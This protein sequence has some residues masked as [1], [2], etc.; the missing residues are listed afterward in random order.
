MQRKSVILFLFL[1]LIGPGFLQAQ[2][3]TPSTKK[4]V[5]LEDVWAYFTFFPQFGEGFSWMKDDQYYIVQDDEGLVQYSIQTRQPVKTIFDVASLKD[6][7]GQQLSLLS[8]EFNEDETKLLIITESR[9][10]YRRSALQ[11][12]YVWDI[13]TQKL[14]QL[15]A[16]KPVMYP[17]FSPDGSKIAYV[18]DNDLYFTELSTGKETRM[19]DDGKR[20]AIIN[21]ATDWVYEEEFAFTR[22]FEWSPDNNRIAFLQFNETDVPEYSMQTFKGALYPGNYEFKYPKAGEK[23]AIVNLFFYDLKIGK[24]VQGNLGSETDQYI[25][26]IRFTQDASKLAVFRLNRLQNSLDLLMVDAGT[27]TSTVLMNESSN[28]YVQELTDSKIHF[29][30]NGKGFLYLSESS[31]FNHIYLYGMD[32]KLQKAL[33]SGNWEVTDICGVDEKNGWIYFLSTEVS[34]LERH[35]NRV[36]LNGGTPQQL[37]KQAGMHEIEMSTACTYYIDTWSS[38]NTPPVMALYKASGEEVLVLEDNAELKKKLEGYSIQYPEFTKITTEEGVDLNGWMIKPSNFDKKKK[39]PVLLH[40]YGGPGAQEVLNQ[41]DYFDLFWYQMLADQGYIIACFDNR[42]TGGRGRDFRASTYGQLG[43]LECE[44]QIQVAKWL[45]K[46]S[47]VDGSRIGIWGWSFGGYLSSLC[48]T[49]GAD[50]FKMAIAVAPV[51]NWRFYDTIYTERYL[52]TPQLNPEGYDQ[53]SPITHT[54]KLK[55]KYLLVH[56]TGDDNV[57]FQNSVEMV[58]SLIKNN[59]QF[60]MAYYPDRN[61]GISGGVTRYHLYK[62]MTDFVIANL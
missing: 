10:V 41:W 62:K 51:T 3:N 37:T 35:L 9:P 16:G 34:P 13:N 19:T 18:G 28:T 48:I 23:N 43:K 50:V 12:C 60:D 27:G 6:Q 55:G 36:S 1:A 61:H 31:G 2:K 47:W 58:N 11:V 38:L 53:N 20:N 29:L 21:G 57:H 54:S 15:H 24:K 52:K 14:S 7:G 26:R 17:H 39:Y 59:K 40:C 46:Q 44:D 49:K 22:A 42:G 25:P 32:G 56:G 30:K 8:Y 5:T 4:K 45:Q 33:T